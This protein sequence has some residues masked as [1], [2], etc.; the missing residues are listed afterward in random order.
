MH[1]ICTVLGPERRLGGLV[2]S[3][4]GGHCVQE[5]DKETKSQVALFIIQ[6]EACS[7]VLDTQQGNSSSQGHVYIYIL[8]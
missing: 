7:S 4:D 5:Q 2:L 3:L 8:P 1:Q 6:N